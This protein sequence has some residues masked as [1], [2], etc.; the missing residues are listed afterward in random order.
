MD[1]GLGHSGLNRLRFLGLTAMAGMAALGWR[2]HDLQVV[3]FQRYFDRARL[4]TVVVERKAAPRGRLLDCKGRPLVVNEPSYE[5]WVR[6]AEL[7]NLAK[8]EAMLSLALGQPSAVVHRRLARGLAKAP[9]EALMLQRSL[10]AH[11]LARSAVSLRGLPGVYLEVAERRRYRFGRAAA[12]VLGYMGEISDAELRARPRGD[13]SPRDM[14]GKSGLE[15]QYDRTLRGFKKVE[16]Y[17][18]DARGRTVETDE[19]RPPVAGSDLHLTLDI[20]LQQLAERLLR[21]SVR[22]PHGGAVVVMEV[23][24]G[25]LR[26]LATWPSFDPAPFARGIS[27]RRYQSLIRDPSAPLMCRAHEGAYSPGSTFKVINSSAGLAEKLCTP[28]TVFYCTGSYLGQNCFVTSG[29]GSISFVDSIAQSCDVV[30]YRMADQLGVNRLVRYCRA[31][32]LGRPTGVDL[33]YEESGLLPDPAWK[34]RAW[35]E[36]WEWYD[37]TNMGIGQGMLVVTPLQMA[38]AV[39]AVANGGRIYK[40]YLVE[41]I[42]SRSG[43]LQY[44]AKPRPLRR[45]PVAPRLLAGVRAG[46]EAAVLYGT[47]GACNIPGLA[48]AG[49]TGTVETNGE[50]HTWFVS[51]APARKPRLV[52]VVFLEKSGGYGGSKAAPIARQLYLSA[53]GLPGP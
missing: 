11:Q 51:Y 18:V 21:E 42:V 4:N 3:H 16:N 52:I 49:K 36:P 15:K 22:P 13:Y 30:Y 39:A 26:A 50:N 19:A 2:F 47:G 8:T 28:N 25:R 38:V 31:F 45:V 48:V 33:P 14:V 9:L 6:P 53:F 27:Q 10:N 46:M 5:L 23:G 12:N 34:K 43:W 29:H 17:R 35:G 37:T 44:R 7:R 32:G 20:K 24:S 1:A 40:P 41:R